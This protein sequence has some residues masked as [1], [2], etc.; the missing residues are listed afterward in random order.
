MPII[1]VKNLQNEVVGNLPLSDELF[2]GDVNEGLLWEVVKHYL[3]SRRAGTHATKNRGAVSC[4]GKKPWRQKGTGRARVGSSRDPLWKHGGT[5]HGPQPRDYSFTLPKQKIR[6]A[7]KSALRAKFN[8]HKLTVIDEFKLESHK[9]KSLASLLG[10]FKLEKDLLIVD[11]PDNTSLIRASRN[12]P[13]VKFCASGQ[14]HT[15]DV[16]KYDHVFFSRQA[17]TDLQKVLTGGGAKAA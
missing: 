16:I 3:A 15:Y 1:E 6:G 17:I 14:V 4:G 12:L 2:L 9:T 5:A 8:D 13:A 7:L 10:N 11:S